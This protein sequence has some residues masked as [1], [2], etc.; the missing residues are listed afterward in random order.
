MGP[1]RGAEGWGGSLWFLPGMAALLCSGDLP[2][3]TSPQ[4]PSWGTAWLGGV[5]CQP[6]PLLPHRPM[7]SL[8][9]EVIL[10]RQTPK[11]TG[12]VPFLSPHLGASLHS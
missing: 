5:L 10:C 12:P 6:P 9:W 2:A 7:R 1:V 8:S 11:G 3:W 4:T